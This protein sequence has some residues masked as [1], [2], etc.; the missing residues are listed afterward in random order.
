MVVDKK[1]D[2]GAQYQSTG[3]K[4]SVII[5]VYSKCAVALFLDLIEVLDDPAYMKG[6]DNLDPT[7][8][9]RETTDG[10]PACPVCPKQGSLKRRI[11]TP[12]LFDPIDFDLGKKIASLQTI[13]FSIY[14]SNTHI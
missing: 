7:L 3:K 8:H 9:Q 12:L 10:A 14:L 5:R 1:Q 13:S 6:L 11:F 2:N 4:I